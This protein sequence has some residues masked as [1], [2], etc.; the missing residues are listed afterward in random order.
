MT[1]TTRAR[2]AAGVR[3]Y[4]TQ[5]HSVQRKTGAT[6]ANARAVVRVLRDE[7]KR[8][9]R[10]L[11]RAELTKIERSERA[12]K[13][14]ETRRKNEQFSLKRERDIRRARATEFPFGANVEMPAPERIRVQRRPDDEE[15]PDDVIDSLDEFIEEY[16]DAEYYDIEEIEATPSYK[17]RGK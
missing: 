10:G 7:G 2:I 15:I 11:T 16:D 13:G 12:R 8:T 17:D 5:V 14:W 4:W 9:T 3:S 1:K 6:T